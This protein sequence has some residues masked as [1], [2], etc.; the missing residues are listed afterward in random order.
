MLPRLAKAETYLDEHWPVIWFEAQSWGQRLSA[1]WRARPATEVLEVLRR[2]GRCPAGWTGDLR[3]ALANQNLAALARHTGITTRHLQRLR[4]GT[5]SRDGKSRPAKPS[6]LTY[7]KVMCAVGRNLPLLRLS[8]EDRESGP[9]RNRKTSIP[10]RARPWKTSKDL[11]RRGRLR[12]PFLRNH[13]ALRS[14][15]QKLSKA[16]PEADSS[17]EVAPQANRVRLEVAPQ[18]DRATPRVAPPT[19]G[20]TQR[21]APIAIGGALHQ[22]DPPS[23]QHRK[24]ATSPRPPRKR[25]KKPRHRA[26]RR[27]APMA[28]QPKREAKGRAKKNETQRRHSPLT[29][30]ILRYDSGAPKKGDGDGGG[31]SKPAKSVLDRFGEGGAADPFERMLEKLGE[32]QLRAAREQ[33]EA[34]AEMFQKQQEAQAEMFQKLIDENRETTQ[35]HMGLVD[36]ITDAVDGR[37]DK[38]TADLKAPQALS[39]QDQVF[40]MFM[41]VATSF[42]KGLTAPETES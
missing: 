19:E 32:M 18:T 42:L 5:R 7:L 33:R 13:R 27:R 22:S 15:S 1:D 26:R 4:K 16:L 3:D 8:G 38:L 36:R 17:G 31:M 39:K 28:T 30:R 37:F 25:S 23:H 11:K 21:V 14:G 10:D 34:Q 24:G 2:V 12:H 35:F 40:N 9:L 41:D 6:F 20:V 29:S